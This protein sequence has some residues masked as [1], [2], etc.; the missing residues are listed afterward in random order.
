M[1][2]AELYMKARKLLDSAAASMTSGPTPG[3]LPVLQ[4]LVT[5]VS[6]LYAQASIELTQSQNHDHVRKLARLHPI[7]S[8]ETADLARPSPDNP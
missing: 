2:T 6:D 3:S 7:A 1:N 8:E 5:S 4:Q